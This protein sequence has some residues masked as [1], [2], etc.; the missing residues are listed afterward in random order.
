MLNVFMCTGFTHDTK[1]YFM[2]ASPVRPGD[3]IE[4]FAEINLLGALSACPVSNSS[5]ICSMKLTIFAAWNMLFLVC[6]GLNLGLLW[7]RGAIVPRA[8]RTTRRSAIRCSWKSSCPRRGRWMAG[9]G[10][11]SAAAT[12]GTTAR[13]SRPCVRGDRDLKYENSLF[14]AKTK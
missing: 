12:A 13:E 6:V 1:Q 5:S 11:R 14:R 9:E 3:F 10:L 8:I 4:F 7:R 2:K